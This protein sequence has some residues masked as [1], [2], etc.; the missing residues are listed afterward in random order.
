MGQFTLESLRH[1][2][3]FVVSLFIILACLDIASYVGHTLTRLS[4]QVKRPKAR[5]PTHL[6]APVLALE[7][8][9]SLQNDVVIVCVAVFIFLS[10]YYDR[11]HSVD[12]TI[13]ALPIAF[14]IIVIYTY[15]MNLIK[16]DKDE[17]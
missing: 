2:S 4:I 6:T 14:I 9:K 16:V 3:L 11:I 8:R 15:V 10:Y 13:F 1:V 5:V 12:K 7:L 17:H